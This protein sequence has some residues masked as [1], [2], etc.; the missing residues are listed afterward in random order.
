MDFGQVAYDAYFDFADGK[1][2][3][4][5]D[6]LP[7]WNELPTEIREAWRSAAQA[8]IDRRD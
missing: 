7:S 4:T 1:S 6:L 5:G 8:V 3:V 2:L